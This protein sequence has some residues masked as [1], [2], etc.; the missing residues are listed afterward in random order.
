M[1]SLVKNQVL[2]NL[3]IVDLTLDGNGVAKYDNNVIFI[4]MTAIGD[5]INCKIVKVLKSYSFGI[6][7][8]IIKQSVDRISSDCDVF[9]QCGGC[10]FRH[11]DYNAELSL[12]EK[13]V[14]DSFERIGKIQTEILPIVPFGDRNYY[15]NK[16]QYPVGKDINGKAICGFYAKRSHRIVQYTDCLLQPIV[17]SK[18]V[19]L[20]M[21]YVNNSS[22]IPYDEISNTGELRHI[23]IRKG[24]HTD[25][26]MVCLVCRKDISRK[27]KPLVTLLTDNFSN[28]KSIILNINSKNTNV[29]LG[30]KNVNLYGKGYIT[31]IMCENKINLSPMAFY[32]INTPQAERLYSI[33]KEFAQVSKDDLILDLYCGTGTIGLS[34]AKYVKRLIGVDIVEQSIENAKMNAQQN[35]ITNSTFICGDTGEVTSKLLKDG[36]FPDVVIVDPARKGCDTLAINTI[37]S[38]Q[39]DRIVMISC[40]HATASR[41][42]SQFEKLG[43]KV[44]KVQPVDMFPCT[45]HVEIVVLLTQNELK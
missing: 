41:D 6:I 32:Q 37:V 11:I 9:S 1:R 20:I 16:A 8:E 3:Q 38:M 34:M 39:P 35:G 40:N 10:A 18:I 33:A 26:I 14:R 27:L 22:I 25:E 19:N 2:E 12:K 21:D 31:D 23:Y 36:T 5:V 7:Q 24:Y 42:C 29:I 43:Y 17:F 44:Q 28:I 13:S 4:P 45:S 15:R 30:E